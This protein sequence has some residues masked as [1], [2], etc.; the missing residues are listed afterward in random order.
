M[1]H[2]YEYNLELGKTRIKQVIPS[3]D[4]NRLTARDP[5]FDKHKTTFLRYRTNREMQS[6][7]QDLA[8]FHKDVS[9]TNYGKSGD[10]KGPQPLK[11]LRVG[12]GRRGKH[13]FVVASLR[14]CEWTSSLATLHTAMVLKGRGASTRKL[15][16]SVQFHFILLANPDGFDFS[17][18]K[19]PASARAWCKNRRVAVPGYHGVDLERNWGLD[20]I[21][22]G[23]G[24]R[25]GAKLDNFQGPSN[26]SEP[27]TKYLRDYIKHY[28]TGRGRVA[29]MQLRCCAGTVTPPQIY[30]R[31]IDSQV[32][33]AATAEQIAKHMETT[34]GSRYAVITRDTTFNSKNTGQL[35]D[36]AYNEGNIDHAYVIEVKGVGLATRADHAKISI[37]PFQTLLRELE[38]AT[39]FVALKLLQLPILGDPVNTPYKYNGFAK[40]TAEKEEKSVSGGNDNDGKVRKDG[41]DHTNKK[42][43]SSDNG[44][45]SKQD[46]NKSNS[47]SKS[48]GKHLHVKGKRKR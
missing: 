14:G 32:N 16:D 8:R 31:N 35:I 42:H 7:A 37:E 20:G 39:A 36:W 41:D 33:V 17:H 10:R 19:T 3:G 38:M 29:L 11:T 44:Q 25:D 30:N 4:Y 2:D 21:S 26:F 28:A 34:D 1:Q 5:I 43:L 12:N 18:H 27:E 24:K 46:N 47:K 45:K 23:F 13:V 22:W 40:P 6:V 48:N 9:F 15:L